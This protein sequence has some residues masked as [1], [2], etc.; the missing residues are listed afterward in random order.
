MEQELPD[1]RRDRRRRVQHRH[2]RTDPP[3]PGPA[4]RGH[5]GLSGGVPRLHH[6]R[7]DGGG[8]RLLRAPHRPLG[9]GRLRAGGGAR[10][11]G[12]PTGRC[13]GPGGRVHPAHRR[14]VGCPGPVQR[15]LPGVPRRAPLAVRAGSAH[16]RQAGPRC[17]LGLH[18]EDPGAGGE[19]PVGD[20]Q[21]QAGRQGRRWTPEHGREV[22][23][24]SE[25]GRSPGPAAMPT[26]RAKAAKPTK[27][28]KAAKADQGRQG[29]QGHQGG[30]GRARPPRRPRPPRPTK[31]A[32]A[33]EG[34]P[35]RPTSTKAA[36]AAKATKASQGRPRPRRRPRRSRPPRPRRRRRP[37]RPTKATKAT[38]TGHDGRPKPA[39][40]A[41]AGP[42][43]AP[44]HRSSR[45]EAL[46]EP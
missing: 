42:N 23:A 20:V 22:R 40:L 9:G 36:K 32:K 3:Q 4:R 37:P 41:V 28:A 12:G 34:Q 11:D 44:P 7:R 17:R 13:R 39:K 8:R 24:T 1:R 33:T 27:A 29:D 10:G 18:P 5:P 15:L 19:E 35:R 43:P 30:Q 25:A 38:G 16:R 6:L 45:S 2:R 31:A 46:N 26:S 14:E 21:V